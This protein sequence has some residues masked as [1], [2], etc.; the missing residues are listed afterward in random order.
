MSCEHGCEHA[1][2]GGRRDEWSGRRVERLSWITAWVA[3][4]HE[5]MLE[6]MVEIGH[7]VQG[8]DRVF[9]GH[10]ESC[11]QRSTPAVRK[12]TGPGVVIQSD[13]AEPSREAPVEGA[14]ARPADVTLRAAGAGE[15]SG[16]AD[17]LERP[18]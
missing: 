10:P 18:P 14:A 11:G 2:C 7:F 5:V 8:G 9:Y 6:R 3:P 16:R 1:Q 13:Q 15:G 4:A 12:P 17:G